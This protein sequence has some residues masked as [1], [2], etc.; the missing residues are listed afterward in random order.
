MSNNTLSE[1]YSQFSK[2]ELL[3]IA[4]E[5]KIKN[6]QMETRSSVITKSV[7]DDLDSNGV[8]ETSQCSDLMLEFLVAAEYV[9]E[10]GNLIEGEEGNDGENA[11][12]GEEKI[13]DLVA[14]PECYSFADDRD[15]A[16]NRCKVFELCTKER[17]SRRPDCFGKMYSES[18]DECR[19]C[20]EAPFCVKEMSK[21]RV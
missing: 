10:E 14:Y 9:D 8:P 15:P 1:L 7:L 4:E 11:R 5:L 2:S 3:Q 13:V 20:I 12:E 18:A 6:V 19:L 21:S 16:C 17:I